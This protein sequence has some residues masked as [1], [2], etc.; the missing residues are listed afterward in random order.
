MLQIYKN[1]AVTNVCKQAV[2][3]RLQELSWYSSNYDTMAAQSAMLAGFAFAQIS[4]PPPVGTNFEL[5]AA[6]VS[7]TAACLGFNLCV[8]MSCTFCCIFGKGLALRGD[9]GARSVH[10]AVDNMHKEQNFIFTQFLLGIL[11]FLISDVIKMWIIFRPRV[12][13][14]VSIPLCIFVVAMVY[15]VVTLVSQLHLSDD[16][17][18][19]GKFAAW[20]PYERLQDLDEEVY[21]PM[22]RNNMRQ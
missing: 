8:C 18:V 22:Y 4:S 19:F 6:Y 13:L 12:A 5:M 11:T 3:V 16:K 15:Y 1:E 10:L 14:T 17:A 20:T 9:S 7:L 21:T 2:E